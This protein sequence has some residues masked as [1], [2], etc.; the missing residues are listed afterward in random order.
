MSTTG[1]LIAWTIIF[2]TYLRFRKAYQTQGIEV[3]EE[4]K[5]PL[6]PALAWYGLIWS[7]FLSTSSISGRADQSLFSGI[8]GF[9]AEQTVLVHSG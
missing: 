3:V 2:F 7:A 5:S 6:Q 9:L 1:T 8:L 4:S